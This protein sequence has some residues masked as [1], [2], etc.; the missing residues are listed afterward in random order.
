MA[1]RPIASKPAGIVTLAL[2]DL[3]GN[4]RLDIVAGSFRMDLLAAKLAREK[5]D[6]SGE[7]TPKADTTLKPRIILL[8]NKS[9]K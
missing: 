4:G 7:I 1:P 6:S 8:E 2:Q 5:D 9:L 3:T